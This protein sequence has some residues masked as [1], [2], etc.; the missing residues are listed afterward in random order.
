MCIREYVIPEKYEKSTVMS[1]F[2]ELKYNKSATYRTS[3][4]A[5]KKERQKILAQL[6]LSAQILLTSG[7]TFGSEL[8]AEG[9][10]LKNALQL[11]LDLA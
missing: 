5:L 7:S 4:D 8:N 10:K 11:Y 3:A 6:P 2:N 9:I 1:I